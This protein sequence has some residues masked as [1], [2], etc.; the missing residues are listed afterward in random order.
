MTPS[1]A[2]HRPCYD[3]TSYAGSAILQAKETAIAKCNY[4]SATLVGVGDGGVEG[5]R[6]KAGPPMMDAMRDQT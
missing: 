4:R 1:V 5:V 6:P 2:S 3:V